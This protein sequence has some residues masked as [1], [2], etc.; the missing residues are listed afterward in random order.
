MES[1]I[2]APWPTISENRTM[3]ARVFAEPQEVHTSLA[4]SAGAIVHLWLAIVFSVAIIGSPSSASDTPATIIGSAVGTLVVA[5]FCAIFTS[6]IRTAAEHDRRLVLGSGRFQ[7]V[8][9]RRLRDGKPDRMEGYRCTPHA[10][11]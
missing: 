7:R 2:G 5:T 4:W 6:E 8:N 9:G 1:T 10:R 3:K 11:S